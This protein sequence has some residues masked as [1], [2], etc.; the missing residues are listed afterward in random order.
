MVDMQIGVHIPPTIP[1][2]HLPD[3]AI[4][5]DASGLDELWVWEDCFKQSGLASAVAALAT[6]ERIRVGIGL[7][8]VPLRNAALTAMELATVARMFPD[9]LIAGIGHG[10]QDWM[11]QAGARVASPLTLLR[12][13]A[14]AIR[15][16]LR[17][18]E[19]TV[20]GRYVT[21]DRVRL[22]WPP[23]Q[24]PPL[25]VGGSGPRSVALAAQLGD[26]NLL[27]NALTEPQ[28]A[29]IVAAARSARRS[30]GVTEPIEIAVA[31]LAATGPDARTRV[32][33]ELPL[34]GGELGGG[35]GVAGDAE[36]IA[37]SARR[38]ATLGVTRFGLQPTADEPDL[39]GLIDFLGREV[40]PLAR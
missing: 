9:R 38:H 29:E 13:Q 33:R 24:V 35:A 16:L 4:A 21:L 26:G 25:M 31:Q 32:D 6:T 22:E 20:D 10:V 17:G 2:E 3:L 8:P 11:A 5:A 40:A 37:A 23:A 34:W 36:A 1:P 7:M 18:D 39:P 28:V 14:T 19:V 27:T 15:Q 30:A 12:E